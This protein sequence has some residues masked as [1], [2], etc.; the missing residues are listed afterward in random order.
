MKLRDM[1]AVRFDDFLRKHIDGLSEIEWRVLNLGEGDWEAI[2]GRYLER[3]D[4]KQLNALMRYKQTYDEMERDFGII[5]YE[6]QFYQEPFHKSNK[7]TRLVL[8]GNQTGKT[9][10]GVAEVLRIALGIDPYKKFDYSEYPLMIRVCCSDIAKGLGEVMMPKMQK[11]IP[12]S[13]V[14]QIR[15]HSTGQ[16]QKVT[17]HNGSTIEFLSYEQDTKFYEGWTGHFVHFD[18]PPPLEKFVATKRGLMRHEGRIIITATPL[19]EPWIYDTVY[20]PGIRGDDKIDVFQFSLFDNKYLTDEAR[21]EFIKIIPD[22]EREAR[23]YGKF[24]HLTGL[25]YKAFGSEHC[26]ESFEIPSHWTRI[27]ACDFHPRKP[28]VFVWVAIDENDVAYVYDELIVQGTIKQIAE[29]IIGKESGDKGRVRYRFI[30]NIAATPDRISGKCP[31]RELAYEGNLLGHP[32]AFRNSTKDWSMGMNAVSEYLRVV[33]GKPGLYFFKD[34]C[35]KLI[36]S[37]GR[38]TWDI[39]A[40]EDSG[41]ERPRKQFDDLPDALRYALVLKP[42]YINPSIDPLIAENPFSPFSSQR[43][44]AGDERFTGYRLGR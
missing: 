22:E 27:C 16:W 18:E 10:V 43:R 1:K 19:N 32:L 20:M 30:D 38:Y 4:V 26:I 5:Y 29:R 21:A 8:G 17:F 13:E 14:K 25:V 42:R 24:K 7:A 33:N 44:Q 35:P 28:C 40:V 9:E 31:Q 23:V 39:K 34:K 36:E 12:M 3:L 6:P 37:M 15:R 2:R 11:L 41:K